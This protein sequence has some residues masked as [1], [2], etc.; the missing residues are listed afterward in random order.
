M[1]KAAGQG[2][3]L[4]ER[5]RSGLC[6]FTP[7]QRSRPRCDVRAGRGALSNGSAAIWRRPPAIR[8]PSYGVSRSRGR[9]PRASSSRPTGDARMNW[10][11]TS[12]YDRPLP[13][14]LEAERSVLGAI[15]LHGEAFE[16]ASEILI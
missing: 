12:E 2:D 15:L 3:L 4:S 10:H 14:N 6:D 5:S 11:P 16:P 8:F 7:K 9:L 13:H 1:T